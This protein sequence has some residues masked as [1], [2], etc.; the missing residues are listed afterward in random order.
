[1]RRLAWTVAALL[2]V[3]MAHAGT[4]EVKWLEDFDKY[5][6]VHPADNMKSRFHE[7]I[8]TDLTAHFNELA[9]SLPEGYVWKIDVKDIDLAGDAQLGRV[10]QTGWIRVVDDI[11]FPKVSFS[12]DIVN[13]D[14]KVVESGTADVKDMSFLDRIAGTRTQRSSFLYYERDMLDQWFRTTLADKKFG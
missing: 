10:G 14:G 12:Y 8:K 9:A 11:Y 13:R 6:D 3:P 5:S 4:A 7:R 1:M 2:A